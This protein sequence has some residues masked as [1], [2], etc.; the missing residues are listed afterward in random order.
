MSQV[1]WKAKIDDDLTYT[2][3]NMPKG[4]TVVAAGLDPAQDPCVW[5]ACDPEADTE[6]RY[7]TVVG[8]GWEFPS[9]A[10]HMGTFLQRGEYV[11]H[12]LELATDSMQATP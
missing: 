4:A 10:G 2:Y 7:F 12:I 9:S 1:I 5:F 8:T 3:V 11:F 6:V